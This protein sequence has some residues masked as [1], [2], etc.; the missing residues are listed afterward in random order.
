MGRDRL[1]RRL[2]LEV[3]RG[4][5]RGTL[6]I[7][8]HLAPERAAHLEALRRRHPPRKVERRERANGG[9]GA[10]QR[11]ERGGDARAFHHR[12]GYELNAP[13]RSSK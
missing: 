4:K 9:E 3:T 2:A 10:A 1:D 6:A 12:V 13:V 8:Q 7:L 11:D 5:R